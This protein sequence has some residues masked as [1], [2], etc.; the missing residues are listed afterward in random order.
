M[1]EKDLKVIE[2]FKSLVSQR[3]KVHEVKIFGSR[4]R[5]DAGPESD[6]DVF[7][8]VDYLDHEIEKYISDCAWESGFPEDIVVIPIVISIDSL[9]NS[10]IKESVFIHNVYREGIAV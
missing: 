9:R 7:I 3:V 6:L 5:G 8:V 10:P 1:Q 2:K 4:A